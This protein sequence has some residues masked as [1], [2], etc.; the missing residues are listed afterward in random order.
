ME[1]KMICFM[2]E[3]MHRV[4][5]TVKMMIVAVMTFLWVSVVNIVVNFGI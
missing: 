2:K 4:K 1:V 3:V 5:T